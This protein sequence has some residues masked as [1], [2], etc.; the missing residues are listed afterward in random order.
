MGRSTHTATLLN[1]G[2][3]LITG[4]PINAAVGRA[5][6]YDPSTGTFTS[7]GTMNTAR[8]RHTATLLNNGQVLIDGGYDD[9]ELRSAELY[10]PDSGTFRPP[11]IRPLTEDCRR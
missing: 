3:V 8:A 2:K 6:L 10:D 5:D 7:T 4:G 1:N 9:S 11:V